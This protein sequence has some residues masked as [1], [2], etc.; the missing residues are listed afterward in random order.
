M[1]HLA[2]D[3]LAC[4]MERSIR[5]AGHNSPVERRVS[6]ADSKWMLYL[7]FPLTPTATSG[8]QWAPTASALLSC[9][10]TKFSVTLTTPRNKS[11][12]PTPRLSAESSKE[13]PLCAIGQGRET[14]RLEFR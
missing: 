5:R 1:V 8:T 10:R 2:R 9:I 12:S 11:G 6:L 4:E 14:R 13:C 7:R 3:L